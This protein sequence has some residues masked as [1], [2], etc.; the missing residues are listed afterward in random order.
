VGGTEHRVND[1]AREKRWLAVTQAGEH[2]TLGRHT[3]PTD[4]ELDQIARQLDGLGTAGWLVVSEG[5]YHGPGPVSLLQV[6]RLTSL[7]GDWSMAEERWHAKR[8]EANR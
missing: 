3:D 4:A 5:G 2:V 6:R 1:P 8:S 7:D